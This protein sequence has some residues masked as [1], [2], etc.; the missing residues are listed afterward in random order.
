[1][2]AILLPSHT[3]LTKY[4]PKIIKGAKGSALTLQINAKNPPI[5]HAMQI[6]ESSSSKLSK[7]S[8][9]MNDSFT[10][11]APIRPPD[12]KFKKRY[13]KTPKSAIPIFFE[14]LNN[15]IANRI[16]RSIFLI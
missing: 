1:M 3:N 15:I 8:A 4:V 7:N 14:Y 13:R 6:E 9:K 12:I 11:P 16:N 5:I 2:S 10:S